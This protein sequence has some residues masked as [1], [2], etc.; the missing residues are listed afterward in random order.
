[1][2]PS[3]IAGLF[4]GDGTI[5]IS[6][7]PNG[8]QLK[9]ELTQCNKKF[10]ED[11]NVGFANTGKLYEDKREHKYLNENAWKLR[12]VGEATTSIL[13]IM[14]SYSIIKYKQA[15]LG[16]KYLEYQ[17]QLNKYNERQAMY[18][19]MKELNKHKS[20][21]KP[22]DRINN[23][24]ISGLFD[25]EGNVYLKETGKLKYYVKITQMCDAELI[26]RIQSYLGY[27]KISKSEPYRL[28]FFSKNDIF[29][30]HSVI[31]NT[32]QIKIYDILELMERLLTIQ[33]RLK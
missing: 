22:Y 30:F 28:R 17:G 2:D 29:A 26:T 16:I 12:F 33:I 3:Y 31:E 32:N 24:Y 11:I 13:N 18:N 21:I 8:F 23:A 7:I 14:K 9:V 4:D 10:L 1:M 19:D 27:G 25:A 6:Q 20:Y 5:M 15:E